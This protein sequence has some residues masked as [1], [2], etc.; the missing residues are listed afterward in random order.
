MKTYQVNLT[1]TS[2]YLAKI[3][4]NSLKEAWEKVNQLNINDYQMLDGNPDLVEV[5]EIV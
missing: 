5:K 1:A 2:N 4:A 3:K